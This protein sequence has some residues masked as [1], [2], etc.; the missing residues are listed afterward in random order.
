[1]RTQSA[2]VGTCWDNITLQV[3]LQP[4]TEKA[5][6]HIDPLATQLGSA[7]QADA[8]AGRTRLRSDDAATALRAVRCPDV[9]GRVRC[10]GGDGVGSLNR[11]GCIIRVR[12]K[13][14]LFFC[15]VGLQASHHHPS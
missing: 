9:V 10:L 1:M 2:L 4:E 15:E 6:E 12:P 7:L 8:L 14:Y 3:P 5:A 13:N 11:C